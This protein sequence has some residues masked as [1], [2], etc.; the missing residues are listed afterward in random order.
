M[1]IATAVHHRDAIGERQHLGQLGRH[2]QNRLA[3]L[4]RGSQSRVN[5]LDRA[6][7]HAARRLRREQHREVAP[8]S[9]AMTIFCWLPPESARAGSAA[10]GGRMSNALISS[11]GVRRDAIVVESSAARRA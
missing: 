8:I 4:T 11:R 2:E 3:R 10:S 9:R 7:V 6:D 1:T 5:E